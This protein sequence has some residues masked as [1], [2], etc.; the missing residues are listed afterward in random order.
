MADNSIKLFGFEIKRAGSSNNNQEKIKS[1]VPKTDDDGA[2][3]ITASGSHFGQYL[4]IDGSAAKDNYQL[5][6]KYRGVALHPEVDNAIEDI[7][8]EAIVATDD[9][10]PINLTMEDVEFPE[11]IKEQIQEEFHEILNMLNFEE[12]GHDIF[13]RWYI[14]GRV[15]H[16][17]VVD[18][19]NEK[20]GRPRK[21]KISIAG[22]LIEIDLNENKKDKDGNVSIRVMGKSFVDIQTEPAES[23]SKSKNVSIRVLGKKV[24]DINHDDWIQVDREDKSSENS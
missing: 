15:Y 16:H 8:N 23:N 18:E 22:G 6:R 12:N 17:L 24:V 3:Y 14:D 19:K 7:V 2:G 21:P 20:A 5:I 13:R 4:D 10:D 1:V 11:K 9:V